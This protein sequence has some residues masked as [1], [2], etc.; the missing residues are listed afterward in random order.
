MKKIACVEIFMRD[1]EGVIQGVQMANGYTDDDGVTVV[2]PNGSPNI[3]EAVP[4]D[5]SVT[6]IPPPTANTPAELVSRVDDVEANTST[7]T[8]NLAR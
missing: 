2:I 5:I 4:T 6:V 1:S 8:F 3:H 7:L